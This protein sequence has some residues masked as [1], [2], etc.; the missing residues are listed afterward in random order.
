MSVQGTETLAAP[1]LAEEQATAERTSWRMPILVALA[2]VLA[3]AVFYRLAAFDV[4]KDVASRS[5][6]YLG[7]FPTAFFLYSAFTES[8]FLAL[9]IGAFW[10][11]RQ[12][13]WPLAALLAFLCGL[14]KVQG[15]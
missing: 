15:A 2:A 3:L 6:I 11:G 14:T 13:R 4:G 5:V 7:L 9:A 1:A 10:L 8:L 12:G